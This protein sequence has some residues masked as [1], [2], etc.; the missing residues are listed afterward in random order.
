M[1]V[2]IKQ[3]IELE[4]LAEAIAH[5][6]EGII[7]TDTVL[8]LPDGPKIV[9]VNNA[10]CE[11]TGYKAVELVGETPRI[12]QGENSDRK[13]LKKLRNELE[14]GN[15]F[16]CELLNYRKDGTE[17]Y[18][19]LTVSPI[20]NSFGDL[21]HYVSIHHDITDQKIAQD[22][23][24]ESQD[25]LQSIV[26]TAVDAIILIDKNG[27]I[28]SFNKAAVKMFGYNSNEAIGKNVNLLMP[29]PLKQEHDNYIQNYHKTGKAKII[30]I[31]R[32]VTAKRKDG[33]TFPIDLAI[34]EIRHLNLYTGIIRDISVRKSA[35]EALLKERNF[36]NLLIDTAQVI[37]IVLDQQG[38]IVRFN[39]Y[40]EKISGYSFAEVYGKN[41][42]KIFISK[43]EQSRLVEI[44]NQ[45]IN[46][47][48]SEKII[49][50]I[51]TKDGRKREIEWV[52]TVLYDIDNNIQGVLAVGHDITEQ[53]E[54]EQAFANHAEQVQQRIGQ[55]LHDGLGQELTGIGMLAKSLQK[56][57]EANSLPEAHS[58]NEIIDYIQETQDKVRTIIKGV[59]PVEV[60]SNGLMHAIKELILSVRKNYGINCTFYYDQPMLT[61]DN[62][63]AS[64]IYYI[65]QEALINAVKHANANKISVIF[66]PDKDEFILKINDDGQGILKSSDSISGYGLQIIKHRASLI[67]ASISVESTIGKGVTIICKF[68]TSSKFLTDLFCI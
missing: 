46:D 12:L 68:K 66:E 24:C 20:K 34:S 55:E 60:T 43:N 42:I 48:S 49:N 50:V 61:G 65:I 45:V 4:T 10:I 33:S 17:F 44:F 9:F 29:E 58:L 27:I 41:W 25:R 54:I 52:N 47:N 30:G 15:T 11:M 22:K 19:N 67:G 51:L 37:I 7:I 6:G 59:R 23:L 63:I 56:K 28:Q 16:K 1:T 62:F 13:I 39:R 32:E 18:S 8:Q 21:T 40:I 35:E 31:G 38:R 53:R 5:L 26:D 2:G 57:L 36:T 14:S 64:Q 3:N